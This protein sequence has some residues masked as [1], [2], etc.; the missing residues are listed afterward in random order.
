MR[1]F[2][3]LSLRQ[4]LTSI[5]IIAAL[6]TAGMSYSGF[7][8]TARIVDRTTT[9]YNKDILPLEYLND[10]SLGF[11]S[12]R[13]DLRDAIFAATHGDVARMKFF[14]D[15]ATQHL[16]KV[17]QRSALYQQALRTD[18]DRRLFAEYTKA[19]NVFKNVGAKVTTL[20]QSANYNGA[21]EAV[22]TQCIP[23]AEL[24]VSSIESLMAHKQSIAR[25]LNEENEENLQLLAKN[26]LMQYVVIG[27]GFMMI[28]VLGLWL[29]GRI[30][31]AVEATANSTAQISSSVQQLSTGMRLQSTQVSDIVSSIEEMTVTIE[32]NTH[33]TALAATEAE[34]TSQEVQR[35]GHIM[36]Q[37]IEGMT[38][39]S[40]S[41]IRSSDTMVSLVRS[42]EEIE[43][44]IQVISEIADQTNLLA[45]NAAIEAARAGD[46]GRGFAVVADEVRKLAERT[47]KATKEIAG[48]IQ[49]MQLKT[50]E[51]M[52]VM[53]KGRSKAE[54]GRDLAQDAAAAL[55]QVLGRVQNVSDALSRL[56]VASEEQSKASN[57]I[58]QS[59]TVISGIIEQSAHG[60]DQIAV[61]VDDLHSLTS[62]LRSLTTK[63][64]QAVEQQAIYTQ[65]ISHDSLSIALQSPRNQSVQRRNTAQLDANRRR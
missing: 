22:L 37:A 56:A 35:G 60:V 52:D 64:N 8:T 59:V 62:S 34:R 3:N 27:V 32:E 25:Q 18:E 63:T 21:I 28:I 48:M 53:N 5:F 57:E 36:Q 10:I 47:R 7:V 61:S 19:M 58:A 2:T 9:T 50:N 44:I 42:S 4:K 26:R 43:Q 14:H 65:N 30:G 23:A 54:Q 49:Q 31:Y 33:Q 45:L 51:V 38:T 1:W 15:R 20:T 29:S 41:V 17:E 12:I 39:I 11:L 6:L 24:V 55:D 40:D 46:Q 16:A 13:V